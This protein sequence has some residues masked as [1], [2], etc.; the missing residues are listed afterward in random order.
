MLT[1]FQDCD[2]VA[3]NE[4]MKDIKKLAE[5]QQT[6]NLIC[7]AKIEYTI[8]NDVFNGHCID[9]VYGT[10]MHGKKQSQ[11]FHM[12]YRSDHIDMN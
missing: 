2:D 4:F 9:N 5:D 3:M 11:Q 6:A 8:S 10:A 12:C 1:L 7:V